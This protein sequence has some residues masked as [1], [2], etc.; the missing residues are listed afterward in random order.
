MQD[1]QQVVSSGA[2]IFTGAECVKWFMKNMIGV[3]SM[4]VAQVSVSV[5]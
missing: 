5:R 4:Q 3:T 1:I 2:R